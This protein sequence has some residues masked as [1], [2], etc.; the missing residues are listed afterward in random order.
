MK[1]NLLIVT[2]TIAV[3]LL[4]S[5]M[6][7]C[8]SE[9]PGDA[10]AKVGEVYISA[11]EFDDA[12]AQEARYFGITEDEQPD[13]YRDIQRWVLENLVVSELARLE[14]V[15]LAIQASDEEVQER[16]DE[17]VTYYFE[18]D[19]AQLVDQ[20]AAEGMTLEDLKTDIREGIV[21]DKV[22]EEVLKDIADVPDEDVAAYYQENKSDYYV[23]ASRRVR[24]IL[25]V[26]T[27]G[28]APSDSSESTAPGASTTTTVADTAGELTEADWAAALALAE[29]VK[30]KLL[31]GGDWTEL[32]S[33]YSDD[34]KTK[35]NGGDLGEVFLGET[36]AAFEEAAF[37]LG[38]EE[39]SE[40]VRTV[41]GYEIIQAISIT[42]AGERPLDEVRD[43]IESMLLSEA[44]A[45]AWQQWVE[46]KKSQVGVIYRKDLQPTTTTLIEDTVTTLPA[47]S[48]TTAAA[49]TTTTSLQP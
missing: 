6:T 31:A 27:A 39:I 22:Q 1:K 18:D 16:L 45:E 13:T 42:E 47:D 35:D 32:A 43:Q 26:P 12:V 14:A 2:L 38:L 5:L 30:A 21:N 9:L 48:P 11:E 17:Y 24:H 7:G 41:Y 36:I 23:E 33:E 49:Q 44:R 28:S 4:P 19:Q 25:I 3:V 40:P 46:T 10:V 34:L 15:E 29:E 37:A 20:L 8:N